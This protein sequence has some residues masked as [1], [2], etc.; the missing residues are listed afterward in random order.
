MANLDF[1]GQTGG[2][3]QALIA[4]AQDLTANWVDLGDELHVQGAANI[5]LW[6]ELDINDSVNA[7]VR[8][9]AKWES[10]GANEY[11]LP[12]YSTAADLV[13]VEAEY[14]EFNDDVDQSMIL[15]WELDGVVPY[16]QFQVQAGTVGATA[17]QIDSA[18]VT[19]GVY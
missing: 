19:T 16:V 18:Y 14:V 5:A 6:V 3:A 11:V 10:G 8:M 13:H 15:S 2:P 1:P 7:R 17:G 9:L 12:I 4:A